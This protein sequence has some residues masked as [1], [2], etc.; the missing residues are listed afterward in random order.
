VE[1]GWSG[2]LT[3]FPYG[4]TKDTKKETPPDTACANTLIRLL[5][6]SST[7]SPIRDQ[8]K[9]GCI[10]AQIVEQ[11]TT[12]PELTVTEAAKLLGVSRRTVLRLIKANEI[13]F[14]SA[15]GPSSSRPRYRVPMIDVI[16]LRNSYQKWT[17][18]PNSVRRR[19]KRTNDTIELRF[20]DLS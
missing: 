16:N 7:T 17:D 13:R 2:Q 3:N 18:N 11:P 19:T 15:A 9:P 1:C 4:K 20:I 8:P 14:R 12:I 5:V 10:V 6:G